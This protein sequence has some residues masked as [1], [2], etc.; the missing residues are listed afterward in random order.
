MPSLVIVADDLTGAADS[1]VAFVGHSRAAVVTRPDSLWPEADVIAV[2]TESRYL[3]AERA[4]GLARTAAGRAVLSGA[5]VFKKIDSLMRGNI[6][7]ELAG[8]LDA[9][10]SNRPTLAVVAPAFPRTGRTT[11]DGVVHV[12]GVA[13]AAGGDVVAAL[14]VAGLGTRLIRQ[15][16]WSDAASLAQLFRAVAEAGAQAAVVDAAEEEDLAAIASAVEAMGQEAVLVG[17]GGIAAHIGCA[18]HDSPKPGADDRPL[19]QDAFTKDLSGTGP[20]VVIGS[21]SQTGRG[22]LENLIANGLRHVE[23]PP[24]AENDDERAPTEALRQALN[25]GGAVLT[26]CLADPL[27]KSQATRVSAAL[28]SAAAA[29]TDSASALVVSGGETAAAVLEAIR[30]PHFWLREELLPGVVLADLPGHP[31]PF[32]LKSGSFGDAQTLSAVVERL[33]RPRT[34]VPTHPNKEQNS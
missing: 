18:W 16:E 7:A 2:S 34:A 21:Y 3:P 20:L 26:P 32:V 15:G 25:V 14:G 24:L 23:L 10:S 12:D 9:V 1:A 28:A 4:Q 19:P 13:L 11:V 27:D 6:G 22:Q 8:V 33:A 30:A 31:I 29:A 17:T 5:R